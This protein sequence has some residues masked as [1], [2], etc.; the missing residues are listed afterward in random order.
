[1]HDKSHVPN[2]RQ[3]RVDAVAQAL[4][5]VGPGIGPVIGPAGNFAT[6]PEAALWI[7]SAAMLLGRLEVV[8]VLVVLSPTFWRH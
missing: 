8:V 6:L 4:A 1:M 5:N 7:L 3:H 2:R